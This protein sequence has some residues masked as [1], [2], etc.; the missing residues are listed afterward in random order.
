SGLAARAPFNIAHAVRYS[1]GGHLFSSARVAWRQDGCSSFSRDRATGPRGYRPRDDNGLCARSR[2]ND[3]GDSVVHDDVEE[4]RVDLQ[5]AVIF[6]EAQFAEFVHEEIHPRAGRADPC[7]QNLLAHLGDG[8]H[9]SFLAEV[10]QQQQEAGDL[11]DL[12]FIHFIPQGHT[13][14]AVPFWTAVAVVLRYLTLSR[15]WNL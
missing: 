13:Q 1:R 15:D 8:L 12:T 6:D 3:P 7:R 5:L 4:C 2:R 11:R 14:R 10:G 9:L